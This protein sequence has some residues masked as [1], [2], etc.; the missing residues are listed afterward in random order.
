MAKP[1]DPKHHLVLDYYFDN[2]FSKKEA[3][4]S[5]G[6]AESTA[7]NFAAKVFDREDVQKEIKLRQKKLAKKFQL[8][9]DWLIKRFLRQ[10]TAGDTLARFKKIEEDGSLSW[11]FTGATKDDLALIQELGVDFY[12]EGRGKNAKKV[13]KFKIK[14]PDEQAALMALG[15]H[16]GFFH[17]KVEI[18]GSLA[19]RI[20]A[21]R[22]QAYAKAEKDRE[23]E[24]TIH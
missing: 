3:L 17:D 12:T 10:A 22:E 19:E 20:Q 5:A 8:T 4:L 24:N 2:G 18:V 13:K 15:R 6:Y 21:G 11:D 14:T 7:N 16:L 1:L 9:Q 23:G